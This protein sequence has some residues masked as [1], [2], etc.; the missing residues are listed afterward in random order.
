MKAWSKRNCYSMVKNIYPHSIDLKRI[1]VKNTRKEDFA[2][3]LIDLPYRG[4][5]VE[6]ISDGRKIVI[7]KP[8]GKMSYGRLSKEDF[9]VFIYTPETQD[10]WQIS[11]NQILEDLQAKAAEDK[12]QAKRLIDVFESVLNGVDPEDLQEAFSSF[13]FTSGELPEALLKAYKWI[14]GQEDVNYPTGKGRM[15]SWESIAEL[16]DSL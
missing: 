11:H 14:W 1:R 7:T 2:K 10:L 3:A 16:R 5:E 4:Y 9:L 15:M 6:E 13:S 12:E 8:G